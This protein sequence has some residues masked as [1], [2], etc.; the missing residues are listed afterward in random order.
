MSA[1]E[2]LAG[3][4]DFSDKLDPLIT[5]LKS[6]VKKTEIEDQLLK[7]SLIGQIDGL[8]RES[9]RRA[10]QRL[11]TENN[12]REE[13][14]KFVDEAYRA[15]SKIVHEG[16]RVPELD[17]INSRLEMILTSIYAITD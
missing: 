3:Q 9:I 16:Q 2:A 15:R 6:T 4:Q 17:Q 5:K 1:L 14:R 7:H 8:K 10:L 11:L 12:V 13:D